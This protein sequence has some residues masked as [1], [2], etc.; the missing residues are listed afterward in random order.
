MAAVARRRLARR[1]FGAKFVIL[2]T[3][4]DTGDGGQPLGLRFAQLRTLQQAIE[5]DRLFIVQPS[6]NLADLSPFFT[7]SVVYGAWISA[8][9]V[10]T[11]LPAP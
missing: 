11:S 6:G 9:D 7:N 1:P 3:V 8:C 2:S 4:Q 10:R 5:F